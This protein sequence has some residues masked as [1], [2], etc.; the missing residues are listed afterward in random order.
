MRSLVSANGPSV[1]GWPALAAEA[2]ERALGRERPLVDELTPLTKRV[3]DV[4]HEGDVVGDLLGG[5]LV[6]GHVLVQLPLGTAAVV[7][8]KQVLRHDSP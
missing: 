4:A 3:G 2:H 5:P 1:T 7:L 8:E 6:H